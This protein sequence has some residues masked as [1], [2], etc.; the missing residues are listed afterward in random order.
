[1]CWFQGKYHSLISILFIDLGKKFIH[2]KINIEI[3][4]VYNSFNKNVIKPQKP[5]K[6]LEQEKRISN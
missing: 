4:I 6:E 2:I 1:M 3:L 5:E